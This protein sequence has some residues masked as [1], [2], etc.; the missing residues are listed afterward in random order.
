MDSHSR[1]ESNTRIVSKWLKELGGFTYDPTTDMEDCLSHVELLELE[2]KDVSQFILRSQELKEWLQGEKS[3]IFE[4]DVQTPPTSLNNPLSFTSAL[5]ATTIQS[6]AQFPVL[7]FF[8]MHK[9]NKSHIEKNS[10]PIALVKSLNGQLLRF[11]V[12]HRPSADISALESEEFFSKAKRNLKDGLSLLTALISSLPEDDTI[13]VIIDSL[14][15][16]SGKGGDEEKVMK[17]LSRVAEKSEGV[18]LKVMVTNAL[19]GSYVRKAADVSLY[20][21]DSVC[22][23]GAVEVDETS[24]EIAKNLKRKQDV[25]YRSGDTIS[26]NEDKGKSDNSEDGESEEGDDSE[27]DESEEG[28]DEEDDDD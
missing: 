1:Q 27:N 17:K 11:I 24:A 19:P 8:S 23:F 15:R 21:Q 9:N 16:L 13:F 20:V 3:S 14:S 26:L 2:E 28:E 5:L 7:S 12:E 4:V 25:K 6:T 10:G 18:A 22:G